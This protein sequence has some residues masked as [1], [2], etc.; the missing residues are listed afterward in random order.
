MC[1]A[2]V[3]VLV[4]DELRRGVLGFIPEAVPV[5]YTAR[6]SSL[7]CRHDICMVVFESSSEF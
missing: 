6:A 3:Y 5:R 2:C 1:C 7:R 4:C